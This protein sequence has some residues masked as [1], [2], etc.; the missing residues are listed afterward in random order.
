[1]S[2]GRFVLFAALAVTLFSESANAQAYFRGAPSN[3]V[4]T[5]CTYPGNVGGTQNDWKFEVFNVSI[6]YTPIIV[7]YNGQGGGVWR[8]GVCDGRNRWPLFA[9]QWS[10]G[11]G[12]VN[13][14]IYVEPN[15]PVPP[16]NYRII[17]VNQLGQSNFY[18]VVP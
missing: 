11:T 1:M 13:W 15:G 12:G 5:S 10:N 9:Q 17:F 2:A 4:G 7:Y 16:T 14:A 8:Q 18:N 6:D 3:F